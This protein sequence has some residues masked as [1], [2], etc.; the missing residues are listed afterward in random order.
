[1]FLS[2]WN[3]CIWRL[4]VTDGNSLRTVQIGLAKLYAEDAEGGIVDWPLVMA[5][6]VPIM[7]PP[8]LAF[9]AVE[10]HLVGGITLGGAD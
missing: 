1:M 2:E 8:V 5:G 3:W 7:L 6:S 4:I 10:R 9:T